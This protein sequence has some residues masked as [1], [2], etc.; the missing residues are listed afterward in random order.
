MLTIVSAC[1]LVSWTTRETSSTSSALVIT[2]ALA[3]PSVVPKSSCWSTLA[4]STLL[5]PVQELRNLTGGDPLD[6][7]TRLIGIRDQIE[8]RAFPAPRINRRGL[9]AYPRFVR[10]ERNGVTEAAEAVDEMKLQ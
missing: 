6:H 3:L 2:P 1:F 7:R 5:P 8:Q 10:R 4:S 9:S